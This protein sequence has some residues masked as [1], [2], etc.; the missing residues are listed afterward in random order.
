MDYE[1]GAKFDEL[2]NFISRIT[3]SALSNGIP[4]GVVLNVN[5]P[6]LSRKE[7]KGIKICRQAVAYWM[8]EFDKRKDPTGG[9]YYWL[10]GKFIN[11]D[12]GKDTDEWALNNGYISVVPVHFDMTAHHTIQ[13]LNT[14]NF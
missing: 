6:K 2:S 13:K 11:E 9:E 14:W 12:K 1:W 3:L 4:K 7:I 10:T 5:L 8:E